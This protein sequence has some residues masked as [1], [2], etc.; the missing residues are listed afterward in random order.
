MAGA[1]KILT[2]SGGVGLHYGWVFQYSVHWGGERKNTGVKHKHNKI[3]QTREEEEEQWRRR[4][5]RSRHL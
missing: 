2:T 5:G 1:T 4:D 3:W